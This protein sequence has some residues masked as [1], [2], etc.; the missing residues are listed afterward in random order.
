MSEKKN[1]VTRMELTERVYLESGLS[2]NKCAEIVDSILDLISDSLVRGDPVKL[3]SFGTFNILEKTPRIGRNPKSGVEVEIESRR[4][5]S[6]RA[7]RKTK[8]RVAEGNRR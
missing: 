8:A 6:F 7:S 5:V 3:S 2:R 1:S 4:V